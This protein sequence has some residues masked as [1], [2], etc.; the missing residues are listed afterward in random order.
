[1]RHSYFGRGGSS[2]LITISSGSI[3]LGR[4]DRAWSSRAPSPLSAYRFRYR[5]T[6]G[7]GAPSSRRS[8]RSRSRARPANDPG[9]LRQPGRN[10][11]GL[12][13]GAQ[14][15]LVLGRDLPK[16]YGFRHPPLSRRLDCFVGVRKSFEVLEAGMQLTADLAGALCQLRETDRS[17]HR[18]TASV[19]GLIE[20][21]QTPGS[22]KSEFK[23]RAIVIQHHM[24]ALSEYS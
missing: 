18:R 8:R 14:P 21:I 24:R 9:P 6:V 17:R 22:L 5:I 23:R 4:Q 20:I 7:W 11:P 2:V 13:P 3:R 10:V 15:T 19:E 16:W 1:V 12:G